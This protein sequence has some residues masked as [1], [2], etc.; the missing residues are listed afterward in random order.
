MKDNEYSSEQLERLNEGLPIHKIAPEGYEWV[1]IASINNEWIEVLV[2]EN[3]IQTRHSRKYQ[4]L[5]SS[6]LNF[7]IGVF[8]GVC[9]LFAFLKFFHIHL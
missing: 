9:W 3:E 4:N 6:V 1:R 2:K 5:L 7:I 8:C